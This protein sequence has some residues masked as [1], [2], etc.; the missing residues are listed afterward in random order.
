MSIQA[1]IDRS[2]TGY[3]HTLKIGRHMTRMMTRHET[4]IESAFTRRPEM[5]FA[6]PLDSSIFF[7]P[8]MYC[9]SFTS[10]VKR[11]A[12]APSF[13]MRAALMTTALSARASFPETMPR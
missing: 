10:R 9:S 4:R 8:G 6:V 3:D 2:S 13:A 12:R 1:F 11:P 7:I 5:A